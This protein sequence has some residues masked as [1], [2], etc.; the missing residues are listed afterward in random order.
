M[1]HCEQ[2][3]FWQGKKGVVLQ[4]RWEILGK[5]CYWLFMKTVKNRWTISNSGTSMQVK[6]YVLQYV[7]ICGKWASDVLF[8][9]H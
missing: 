2:S 6:G 1:G 5:V 3:C 9:F 7:Q 4:Y 8:K